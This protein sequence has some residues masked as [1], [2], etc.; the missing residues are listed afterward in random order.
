MGY[1]RTTICLVCLIVWLVKVSPYASQANRR[2]LGAGNTTRTHPSLSFLRQVSSQY[3]QSSLSWVKLP[4]R[5]GS[6]IG[7]KGRLGSER[8]WAGELIRTDELEATLVPAS[9]KLRILDL[10]LLQVSQLTPKPGLNFQTEARQRNPSP[11]LENSRT[12]S[13]DRC[14]SHSRKIEDITSDSPA[15]RVELDAT[16]QCVYL[17]AYSGR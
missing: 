8:E 16:C 7:P 4:W 9:E 13:D 10:V 5:Y 15:G 12:S 17:R 14:V 1:N 6:W 2:N 3:F 11:F